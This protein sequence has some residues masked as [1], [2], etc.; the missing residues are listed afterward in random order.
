M[1]HDG[2]NRCLRRDIITSSGG[3]CIPAFSSCDSME[4]SATQGQPFMFPPTIDPALAA[5]CGAESGLCSEKCGLLWTS[6]CSSAM[7]WTSVD[8]MSKNMD[9]RQNTLD[10][11]RALRVEKPVTQMGQ[12]RWVWPE[13]T[14]ALALGHSLTT[15]HQRLQEVGIQ[16]SYRR[17][18]LYIGRLR[19]EDAARSPVPVTAFSDIAAPINGP[20]PP[21]VPLQSIASPETI[22]EPHAE[23]PAGR[24]PLANLRKYANSRPGFQWDEAP[25]DKEKLF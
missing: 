6:R 9:S 19:R 17:L 8:F 16:I 4:Q 25:P 11:L 15:V 20:T 22:T 3:T 24:D 10:R 13:I 5:F 14:A 12:I 1:L 2:L 7:L 21:P 23:E 18:S